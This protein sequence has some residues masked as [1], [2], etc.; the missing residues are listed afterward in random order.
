MKFID[1]FRDAGLVRKLADK[2][3]MISTRPVRLMEFCGGHTV[4]I[5]RNGIRQLLPANIEMLSGPG[6]PVCVTSNRD[7]D[8]AIALAGLPEVI[9]TTF[10]DMLKVPGS[11]SSLQ[12]TRAAGGDIRIVYSTQ[13]A[14]Q[15]ARDNPHMAV[16]FLGV[17][18]ETTAPTIASAV[19]QAEKEKIINFS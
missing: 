5:M 16:I 2:I 19:L 14:L 17:G 12:Q 7:I 6:C 3:A 11:Y 15:T 9:I 1:E 13:D 8:R 18:F 4:A 10:G